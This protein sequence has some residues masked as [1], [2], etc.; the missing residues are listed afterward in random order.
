MIEVHEFM[1][2]YLGKKRKGNITE[3]EYY[4]MI[5][6]TASMNSKDPSTQVGSCIVKNGEILSI[7]CNNPPKNWDDDKFP[8]GNNVSEIEEINT[9]YPYI[10]HSE[11]DAVANYKGS[12][13][14]LEDSTIY[15]TLF[16]CCNCSKIIARFGI[17]KVLYFDIRNNNLDTLYSKTLLKNCNIECIDFKN[18][19]TEYLSKVDFNFNSEE[20]NIKVLRKIKIPKE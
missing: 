3:E 1:E 12:I 18:L 17:K 7:G 15:V 8:F 19:K 20:K 4:M 11:M 9:K 6:L 5:A 13:K 14:D 16:P 10:I 2:E